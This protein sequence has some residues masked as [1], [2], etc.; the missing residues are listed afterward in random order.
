MRFLSV[1][2]RINLRTH[3]CKF[4][5]GVLVLAVFWAPGI[6]FATGAPAYL[7]D[8]AHPRIW[9]TADVIADMKAK[10]AAND[11]SWTA[12]KSQLDTEFIAYDNSH[13][14][15]F[16]SNYALYSWPGGSGYVGS[17]FYEAIVSAGL[18]Y[19]T[20]KTPA[21]GTG[22]PTADD[23]TAAGYAAW[24]FDFMG[25]L[26]TAYSAGEEADGIEFIR[27]SDDK[28]SQMVTFNTDEALATHANGYTYTTNGNM[29]FKSGY[30]ARSL[31]MTLPI[32]YDWFYNDPLMTS[33]LKTKLYK[34]MYRHIDWYNAVR[35]DYNNGILIGG[36]RYHE[37]PF[38]QDANHNPIAGACSGINNCNVPK[39]E[40]YKAYGYANPDGVGRIGS[41]FY[42]PFAG[43]A[44]MNAVVVYGDPPTAD[45]D[46]YLDY[47]KS[48]WTRHLSE[49]SDPTIGKGG[50]SLEGLGYNSDWHELFYGI[51]AMNTGAG[52]D[53]WSTFAFPKEF[54]KNYIHNTDSTMTTQMYRSSV[55]TPQNSAY[56]L[57][58]VS[59]SLNIFSHILRKY[60]PTSD[61][62]KQLQYFL[63]NAKLSPRSHVWEEF[64]FRDD[65]A[66]TMDFSSEPLYYRSEGSGI[67]TTRSTWDP[68]VTDTVMGQVVLGGVF[69][70]DHQAQ[71]QGALLINRGQDRLLSRLMDSAKHGDETSQGQNSIIFADGGATG[72]GVIA[73]QSTDS[74]MTSGNTAS[75]I[76]ATPLIDRIENAPDY[77]YVSA[78][79]ANIFAGANNYKLASMFRRSL[80][81][82]R[83]NIF[84][85][86]DITK[87]DPVNSRSISNKNK[88]GWFTHY[89]AVP[90]FDTQNQ[91]ITATVGSSKIFVKGLYPTGGTFTTTDQ[92]AKVN[93]T[94]ASAFYQVDYNPA[95]EQEYDQFLHV[96][97]ATGSNVNFMTNAALLVTSSGNMRG[98][99]LDTPI[100]ENANWV[101][102]FSTDQN[103][104]NV[105]GDIT[106]S[107]NS[108]AGLSP[109][110]Y[111]PKLLL[112]DLPP[113]TKY[114]FIPPPNKNVVPQT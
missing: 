44:M 103:G 24:A 3:F 82:I 101:V 92:T 74:G 91:L 75:P 7:P 21:Y 96:I 93:T 47:A 87:S 60:Y 40:T 86:S 46:H 54:A 108:S 58:P 85:V 98:V 89:E 14:T 27:L 33:A 79:V 16:D 31:A 53:T 45:A 70:V 10:K 28:S 72:Y 57:H 48:L 111:S 23:V 22:S 66:A 71:N 83:P 102:L 81:H 38:G 104:S 107:L 88:K 35:S 19:Q 69:N 94:F 97:E 8:G 114:T 15:A 56:W 61:E 26:I 12:L 37:D 64:L 30:A 109:F 76:P 2:I 6:T 105:I 110:G 113:N 84:V 49:L 51:M 11:P 25:R 17:G 67:V 73:K 65:T 5:A 62:S 32:F 4:F 42:E 29:A 20:L 78:D 99:F 9:L 43:L 106:F 63:N 36:T 59:D 18:A 95:V 68:A 80:L 112:V 34:I 39:S 41:N 100:N 52:I 55:H 90:T 13:L 50:D 77:L 1:L